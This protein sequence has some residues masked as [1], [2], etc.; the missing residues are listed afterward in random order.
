MKCH[1]QML[2]G[3][4]YRTTKRI[5][6]PAAPSP[7]WEWTAAV[8]RA[9]GTSALDPFFL[10]SL[11]AST[12]SCWKS[13]GKLALAQP[14]TSHLI[15]FVPVYQDWSGDPPR[16]LPCLKPFPA[17]YVFCPHPGQLLL[18]TNYRLGNPVTHRG[19]GSSGVPGDGGRAKGK[20]QPWGGRS[21]IWELRDTRSLIVKS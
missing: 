11:A 14:A 21:R 20:P 17:P 1:L 4:N 10:A 15:R 13:T 5:S 16:C 18:L 19:P 6:P 2:I 3:I 12:Q 8:S 9:E 7:R